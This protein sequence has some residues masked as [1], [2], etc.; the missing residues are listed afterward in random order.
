MD[1]HSTNIKTVFGWLLNLACAEEIEVRNINQAEKLQRQNWY[2]KKIHAMYLE[3]NWFYD[4]GTLRWLLV[5]ST[6]GK[7]LNYF[8]IHIKFPLANVFVSNSTKRYAIDLHH[9]NSVTDQIDKIMLGNIKVFL[10]VYTH[11]Y[12]AQ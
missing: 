5:E 10:Y 12:N 6:I 4:S 3:C 2:R 11:N 8:L 1:V 9:F 7:K